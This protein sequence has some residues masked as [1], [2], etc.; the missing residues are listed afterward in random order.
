[1]MPEFA[2]CSTTA[3]PLR[4]SIATIKKGTPVGIPFLHYLRLQH[5]IQEADAPARAQPNA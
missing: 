1:M 4:I 2:K 3:L 5:T